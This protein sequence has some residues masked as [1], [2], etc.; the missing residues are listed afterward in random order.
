MWQIIQADDA[1]FLLNTQS[2]VCWTF[3]RKRN[4][5]VRVNSKENH[6]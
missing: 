3:S 4:A 2:G 5:W 1:I 6:G